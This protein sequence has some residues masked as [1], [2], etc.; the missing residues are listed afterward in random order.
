[1]SIGLTT[2]SKL[3]VKLIGYYRKMEIPIKNIYYLLCYAWNKLEERD[4]VNIQGIEATT[5]YDLFAK[6]LAEGTTRLLKMGLE[7]GYVCKSEETYSIRGKID[8]GTSLKRNTLQYARVQCQFDELNH[9][10]LHNQILKSTLKR[11]IEIESLDNGLKERLFNLCFRLN[12]VEDIPLNKTVFRRI[13]FHKN[14]SFYE[15]LLKIC[16]LVVY[17]LLP[18]EQKGQSKFRDFVRDEAQMAVLFEEFIRNFYKIEQ[19]FYKVYRED[20]Y[21][22]ISAKDEESMRY[23]PKMQTDISLESKN[24]KIIIDAKYYREALNVYYDQEKIKNENMRQIS[25]Y[26]DNLNKDV[27]VNKDCAGILLYP[28]VSKQLDINYKYHG[29]PIS[30]KTINLNQDWHNIHKDMLRIVNLKDEIKEI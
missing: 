7:R 3:K 28:T 11:L 25:S 19:T 20:I 17:N 1:M 16:E 18:S 9:N 13:Q 29:H 30:F 15:F 22:D 14:N 24:N 26:L 27:L 6:V 8:F 10:I 21:W 4:I 5:I 23:L 2:P 12:E